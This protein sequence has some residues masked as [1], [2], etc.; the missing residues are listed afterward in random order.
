MWHL[1]QLNLLT[2]DSVLRIFV[3]LFLLKEKAGTRRPSSMRELIIN[4]V[5]NPMRHQ[6][7]FNIYFVFA[8]EYIVAGIPVRPV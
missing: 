2:N 6:F 8:T 1:L 7:V 3:H 4:F 5:R